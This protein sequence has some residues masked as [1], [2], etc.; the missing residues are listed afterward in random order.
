MR[1][2]RALGGVPLV[3]GGDDGWGSASG[4][5][6]A[7]VGHRGDTLR[8][9][10][11]NAFDGHPGQ[12][13]GQLIGRMRLVY[14]VQRCRGDGACRLPRAAGASNALTVALSPHDGP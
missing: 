13:V 8:I 6:W 3:D 4:G 1:L 12:P 9:R 5:A 2:T 14:E 10:G 7:C 11:P